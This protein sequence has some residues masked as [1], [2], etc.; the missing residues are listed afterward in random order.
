MREAYM[1]DLLM[2]NTPIIL[3]DIVVHRSGCP[4]ELLSYGL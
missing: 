1:I 4:C 2:R 3:Q